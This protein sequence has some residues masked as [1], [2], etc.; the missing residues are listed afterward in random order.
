MKYFEETDNL[1]FFKEPV[2]FNKNTPL[3]TL[4]YAIGAN[5]YMPGT[6]TKVFDKLIHNKFNDIGAITL[7]CED[8]IQESD[9]DSAEHNILMILENLA[10]RAK[11]Q[12]DLLDKLPLIFVRVRSVQQFKSFSQKMNKAH[13]SVLAGFNFPKFGSDNG[14]EYFSHLKMLSEKYQETLYGMPILETKEVFYKETRY[15]ELQRIGEILKRYPNYVLNV[16]VGG[17]DFSSMLGVDRGVGYTIYDVHGVAECLIDILNY[18]G[19]EENDYV[20]SGPVYE[21]FS[22]DEGSKEVKTLKKEL[23]LDILNG[24]QGKTIIHPSQI[25][26]VNRTYPVK[27][28]DYIDAINI[29]KSDGGVFKSY[30]GNRMNEANPHRNKARKVLARAEIFGVLDKDAAV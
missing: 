22:W 8:A 7:C 19:R 12:A 2:V 16:R 5:M 18:F 21:Y 26:I 27:Y 30:R 24:F 9:V 25:N 11:E 28:P 17:T 6:Q 10:N 3:D 13:L 20:V 4:R 15:T 29:I 14:E 23:N 1:K